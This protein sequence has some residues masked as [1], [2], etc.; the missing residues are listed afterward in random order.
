MIPPPWRPDI[1]DPHDLVEEVARIVGYEDVPSLLPDAP[2][3]RGL[4]RVQRLR[5]RVGRVVAGAGCVEVISFPFVGPATFDAL[6]LPAGD[7][8]RRTVRLANPLSAEEPE[9]T[10]TLVPGLLKAAARNLGRG[11]PG[12]ALYEIGTVAFPTGRGR[13]SC[14]ST[15][16]PPTRSSAS[17]TTRCRRSRCTS[18]RCWPAR[19]SG[20]AGGERAGTRAGPT[21]SSWCGSWAVSSGSTYGSRPR[22]GCRGTPGAAAAC[23]WAMPSSGTPASCTRR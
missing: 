10:T 4:T 11:R 13:R 22:S 17:S 15:G 7:V 5:R 1:G 21:R 19:S 16:G 8:L 9:Y 2:S 12:L 18:P 14:P 3:G 20:A 6:G 23:S